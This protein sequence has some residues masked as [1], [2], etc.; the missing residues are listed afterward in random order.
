MGLYVI[1]KKKK[2]RKKNLGISATVSLMQ[3]RHM[4]SPVGAVGTLPPQTWR[5]MRRMALQLEPMI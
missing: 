5:R 1:L 2:K 3:Q 4:L